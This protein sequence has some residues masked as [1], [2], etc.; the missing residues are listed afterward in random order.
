MPA[1]LE[2]RPCRVLRAWDET[3]SLR[4]ITVDAGDLRGA[5]TAPGQYVQVRL[6]GAGAEAEGFFALANAPGR[7]LEI[8]V[9]RGGGDAADGLVALEPGSLVAISAPSGPGYPIARHAGRDL[10]LAAAG[11]GIAPMRAVVQHV[12]ADRR[13]YG[14]VRIYQGHRMQSDRAY[15]GEHAVWRAGEVEIV[16]VLSAP[17]PGWTGPRGWVQDAIR[18]DPPAVAR[19]VAYVCGM[20]SMEDGVADVL[21]GLGMKRSD[22]HRNY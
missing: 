7:E 12:L 13:R 15:A 9:K 21:V 11:T 14:A 20:K 17:E 5:H 16:T 6:H 8:L 2:L 1:A 18:N 19:A 22:V 10:I 4:G 3:R